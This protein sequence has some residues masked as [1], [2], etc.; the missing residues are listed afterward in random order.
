MADFMESD[1]ASLHILGLTGISQRARTIFRTEEGILTPRD[2]GLLSQED[3][4]G[5]IS[6][7]NKAYR[8]AQGARRCFIGT[9]QAKK[10]SLLRA[11]IQDAFIEGNH[12]M[13]DDPISLLVLSP[14]WLSELENVYGSTVSVEADTFD[15]SKV[16]KYDGSNWFNARKSLIDQL[17]AKKGAKGISLA[18][19]AR[20]HDNAQ[21]TDEFDTM[22]ERRINCYRHSGPGFD[23]DNRAFLTILM[24]FFN[25]T[26]C[27]DIVRKYESSGNGKLA[28]RDARNHLEGQD[29]KMQVVREA[30]SMLEKANFSG[31]AR[32]GFEDYYKVHVRAHL[33]LSEGDQ[34][35]SEL[36][37]ITKF[38]SKISD[39][40]ILADYKSNRNNPELRNNFQALY[41]HL[42]EGHRFDHPDGVPA[43]VTRTSK[44]RTINQVIGGNSFRGGRGRFN[45]RGRGR[46][47]WGR[48]RGRGDDR[49]VYTGTTTLPPE[50]VTNPHQEFDARTWSSFTYQQRKSIGLLRRN[51]PRSI[52]S[53]DRGDEVSVLSET[54][55]GQ[56]NTSLA[57]NT[58][59]NVST[60]RGNNT[61]SANN[62][63]FS[64]STSRGNS[65][66][67]GS[68]MGSRR[69]N[70]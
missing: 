19:I 70:N 30:N 16:M 37:K 51:I 38:V 58:S 22:E 11:W 24:Q 32:Y 39:Q 46:E 69:S 2:I 5:A 41:N 28:W 67:A 44:K 55:A 33:M 8:N 20:L 1:G 42:A 53:M 23:E 13:Q 60:S 29:Y 18:Y 43:R 3:L 26:S 25:G 54:Q 52:A 4:N 64:G 7:I 12:T 14:A 59:S 57:N 9:A 31:N 62:V 17:K 47:Q 68:A 56:N 40:N 21:W 61:S 49:S 34:P 48:G 45:G 10:I 66:S 27:E 15:S 36:E 35:K 63:S 65:S 50:V 6:S